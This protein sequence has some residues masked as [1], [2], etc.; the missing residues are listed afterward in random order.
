MIDPL[1]QYGS[2][3]ILCH[4]DPITEQYLLQSNI[5]LNSSSRATAWRT[6]QSKLL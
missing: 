1:K 4:I 6:P 5:I 3:V 2:L